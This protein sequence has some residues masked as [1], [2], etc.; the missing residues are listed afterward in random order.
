MFIIT[1]CSKSDA[2]QDTD[3]AP[4]S[5][6]QLQELNQSMFDMFVDNF[7]W[8]MDAVE[9]RSLADAQRMAGYITAN[10]ALTPTQLSIFLDPNF[11]YT[12][13]YYAM[14]TD[15]TYV[16]SSDSADMSVDYR[17]RPWY[18]G[19][20]EVKGAY[21]TA[22]Y[23]TVTNESGEMIITY[24]YP[25]FDA[26][27]EITGVFGID[28]NVAEVTARL[29]PR[30]D[31]PYITGILM[32]T[33]GNDVKPFFDHQQAEQLSGSP[34][35]ATV[36]GSL[37]PFEVQ[38]FG[39]F[40]KTNETL[41]KLTAKEAYARF[42]E[43]ANQQMAFQLDSS[44]DYISF[45][46][47]RNAAITKNMQ[48]TFDAA[49]A[50]NMESRVN[51][52][53]WSYDDIYYVFEADGIYIG[54][55]DTVSST[56]D[57]RTRPWYLDAKE[58]VGVARTDFYQSITG[59]RQKIMTFTAPLLDA[60]G[61]FIGAVGFDITTDTAKSMLYNGDGSLELLLDAPK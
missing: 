33:E 29:L 9:R 5:Q 34:F 45:N 26:S 4:I 14:E 43:D 41:E 3:T 12:E 7:S 61:N 40:S 20:K 57:F 51:T 38:I 18:V 16:G 52:D 58:T 48:Q 47:A 22:P 49:F 32:V 54:L 24:S 1:A 28:M 30:E 35:K 53:F 10:G 25:I 39:D 59:S 2:D 50:K 8:Q 17:T 60:D 13:V 44:T 6:T 31:M 11:P 19:A 21:V 15:G 36:S 46:V 27:G 56:I 42:M 37:R 23:Q 55:D